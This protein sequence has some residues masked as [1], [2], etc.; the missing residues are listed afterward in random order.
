M[1][2]KM[3]EPRRCRRRGLPTRKYVENHLRRRGVDAWPRPEK[4]LRESELTN[5]LHSELTPK[6]SFRHHVLNFEPTAF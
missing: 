2:V 5:R 1:V 6:V 3:S 4:S